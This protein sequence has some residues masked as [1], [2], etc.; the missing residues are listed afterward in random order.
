MAKK[1]RF[2][3][4][5]PSKRSVTERARSSGGGLGMGKTRLMRGDTVVMVKSTNDEERGNARPDI[6]GD[7]ADAVGTAVGSIVNELESLETRKGELLE[8]LRRAREAVSASIDKYLPASVKEMPAKVKE[9]Y[10]RTRGGRTFDRPCQI[11]GF[12]TEPYHDGRLKAHRDQGKHKKAL[13][14]AQLTELEM[15][16]V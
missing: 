9:G 8:Q 7:L 15:R 14:D 12:K 13:T 2:N 6:A 4:P 11:C 5:I 10:N 1:R 16:R 3:G